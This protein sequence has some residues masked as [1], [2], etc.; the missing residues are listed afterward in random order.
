[1]RNALD[2]KAWIDFLKLCSKVPSQKEL[3]HLLDLFLTIEEKHVLA[4]RYAIIKALLEERHTQREIAKKYHV[5]IAQITRGSNALK[6]ID[7]KT[8]DFLKKHLK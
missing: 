4:S 8:K 5:S 3:S 6:I 2:E 7:E 1:M